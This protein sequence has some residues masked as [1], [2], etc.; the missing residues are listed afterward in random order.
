[1]AAHNVNLAGNTHWGC[2]ETDAIRIMHWFFMICDETD[3]GFGVNQAPMK[4]GL[5]NR[6]PYLVAHGPTQI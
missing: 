4:D 1:M 3:S 5:K 2:V 6:L